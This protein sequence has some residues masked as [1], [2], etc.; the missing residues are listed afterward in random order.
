MTVLR[1]RMIDDLRIRNRSPRTIETYVH[2]VARFARHFGRSPELLGA[3]E[4]RTYQLHLIEQDTSWSLFNQCVSALKFLYR[5]TLK[6]GWRVEQVPFAKKPKKL[7]VVLSTGEVLRF[8]D[9]IVVPV[10]RLV[11]TTAYASGLR[12]SEVIALRAEDIDSARMLIHV[13]GKGQKERVVPLSVVLLQGLRAYWKTQRP[14][15]PGS[16]WLFVGA[17]PN[18]HIGESAV[19]KACIRA[20]FKSGLGKHA[21]PHTLR[22]SFATH[23]LESGTDLR[24]VQALLGHAHIATTVIYTHVQRKIVT[25]TQS[26]LDAI[27]R[28]R[29]PETTPAAAP[30]EPAVGSQPIGPSKPVGPAKPARPTKPTIPA[31]P[32]KPTFPA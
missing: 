9:A 23:L 22:H 5:Y 1:Q 25:A 17:N 13:Q 3:E 28:L 26:P 29:Q 15:T 10:H 18:S 6:V 21:T 7:P 2:H 14:S 16:S 30:S 27:S 12:L 24:T 20:R 8:L 11:L 19:Q 31:H 4:I 32:S